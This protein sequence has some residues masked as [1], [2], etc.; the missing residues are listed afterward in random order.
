MGFGF[1]PGA[2]MM[3]QYQANRNLKGSHKSLKDIQ[4]SIPGSAITGR[5]IKDKEVSA[6]KMRE[7]RERLARERISENRKRT[8]LVILFFLLVAGGI[9]WFLS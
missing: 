4:E 2:D 8:F 7:I 1:G 6:E 9:L 3:K 5:A